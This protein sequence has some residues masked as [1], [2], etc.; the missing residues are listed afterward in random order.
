MHEKD[1]VNGKSAGRS[2]VEQGLRS[3]MALPL[4]AKL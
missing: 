1:S 2:A 3:S 4:H